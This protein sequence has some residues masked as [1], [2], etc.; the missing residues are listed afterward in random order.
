GTPRISVGHAHGKAGRHA[1][2]RR[3]LPLRPGP[4]PRRQTAGG[5]RPR[6]APPAV[7]DRPPPGSRALTASQLFSPGPY[8]AA[9]RTLRWRA[10]PSPGP[11]HGGPPLTIPADANSPLRRALEEALAADP[12]DVA[13]HAAYADLL[14]ERGDPLDAARGEL[15][16][17]QLAL[18]DPACPPEERDALRCR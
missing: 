18:E 6:H 8:G 2:Q 14:M 10:G 17:V 12:E 7:A 11:P 9:A 3:Q 15:V 13:T 1:D 16:R 5:R 4:L